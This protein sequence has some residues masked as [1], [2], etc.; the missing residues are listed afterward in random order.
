MAIDA[1]L[2]FTT[3]S[4]KPPL[5]GETQDK[6][7]KSKAA[8]EVASYS[9]GIHNTTTIGSESGGAGA[10]AGAGKAK[11]SE[12]KIEKVVDSVSPNLLHYVGGGLRIPRMELYLRKVG[13]TRLVYLQY[14]FK[15]AYVTDVEWTGGAGED[16]VRE[17]VTFAFGALQVT[18][19]LS[20]ATGATK[21]TLTGAWDQVKNN[22]GFDVPGVG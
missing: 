21:G 8:V 13:G 3:D 22:N 7:F 16:G 18:Y 6:Q 17:S 9:F 20:D 14:S 5:E 15:L 4:S 2:V 10:G 11:F 12:F 19:K 1:F